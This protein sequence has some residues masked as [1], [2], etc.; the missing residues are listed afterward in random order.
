VG[1]VPAAIAVFALMATWVN[2]A[3]LSVAATPGDLLL[4][5][6]GFPIV[7]A[8]VGGYLGRGR[9]DDEIPAWP[10]RLVQL[11]ATLAYLVLGIA[12]FESGDW[13]TGRALCRLAMD[14]ETARF[15]GGLFCTGAGQ[16]LTWA[17]AAAYVVIALLLWVP[18][19]RRHVLLLAAAFHLLLLAAFRGAMDQLVMLVLLLAFTSARAPWRAPLPKTEPARR[20]SG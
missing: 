4:R 13:R 18:L 10:L 16:A 5:A 6:L 19:W 17:L 20:S 8:A 2:L 14:V 3:A 7:L 11:Q 12:R 15:G 1:L 9:S